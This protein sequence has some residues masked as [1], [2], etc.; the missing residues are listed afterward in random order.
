M[1]Q[2]PLGSDGHTGHHDIELGSI[3][4]RQEVSERL[5]DELHFY[6]EST[7]EHLGEI[8]FDTHELA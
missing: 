7:R 3:Q 8:D 1:L 4:G 5:G 6:T 2:A